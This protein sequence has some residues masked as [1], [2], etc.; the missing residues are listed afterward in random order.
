MDRWKSNELFMVAFRRR[1]IRH[2]IYKIM[3]FIKRLLYSLIHI[4]QKIVN[5]PNIIRLYIVA[6]YV[7][8]MDHGA[9]LPKQGLFT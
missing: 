8:A 1:L 2:T 5:P 6:R 3:L 9:H 7:E 4:S